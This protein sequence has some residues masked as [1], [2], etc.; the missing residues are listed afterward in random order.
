MGINSRKKRASWAILLLMVGALFFAP[1]MSAFAQ[2]E[3]GDEAAGDM[4]GA[5]A[6]VGISLGIGITMAGTAYA[7]AKSQA[8]V[9]SAGFGAMAEKP[10]LAT[11]AL[12]LFAIPET[13]IVLG[14]V[15]AILMTG[16][17]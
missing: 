16:Y 1:G 13:I 9:A 6:A 8:A 3:A 11:W 17:F 15:I 5:I 7:T 10:E 4:A 14:F 12:I 2:E